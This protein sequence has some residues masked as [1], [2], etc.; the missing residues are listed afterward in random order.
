VRQDLREMAVSDEMMSDNGEWRK[1]TCCSD[2]LNWE[3][4]RKKKK[5]P[6]PASHRCKADIKVFL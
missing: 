3:K 1:R 5:L 6:A 4:G 2:P